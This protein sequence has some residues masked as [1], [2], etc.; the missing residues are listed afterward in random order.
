MNELPDICEGE[1]CV[2]VGIGLVLAQASSVIQVN[3]SSCELRIEAAQ[4][5]AATLPSI[6]APGLA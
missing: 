6:F 1:Y 3:V 5:S 4:P 2:Q